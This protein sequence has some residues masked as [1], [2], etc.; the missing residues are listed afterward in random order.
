VAQAQP[1]V[2]GRRGAGTAP[3]GARADRLSYRDGW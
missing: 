3:P 2:R 1:V